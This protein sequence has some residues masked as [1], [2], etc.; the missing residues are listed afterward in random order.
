MNTAATAQKSVSELTNGSARHFDGP[1]LKEA[2]KRDAA[3]IPYP[4]RP[5]MARLDQKAA[6][7]ITL[8]RGT[9]WLMATGLVLL[10]VVFSYGGALL[11]WAREDQSAKERLGVV[12]LQVGE[13]R[14]EIKE[15]H[16]KIDELKTSLQTQAERNARAEGYKLGQTDAGATGHKNQ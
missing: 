2:A 1:T 15:L 9:I 13:T 16:R 5:L 10:G 12:E 6:E 11:G 4:R 3:G 14:T 8:S 7:Q